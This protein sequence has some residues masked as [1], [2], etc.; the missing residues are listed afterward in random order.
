MSDITTAYNA[1]LARVQAKLSTH[2]EFANPYKV[3][4][5]DENLLKKGFA[6]GVGPGEIT[7]AYITNRRR[8]SRQFILPITRVV[9]GLNRAITAKQTVTKQ[10]F[11]DL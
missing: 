9:R 11:E 8:F 4:E 5:N 3:D 1:F 2:T 7:E 10:L 6:L